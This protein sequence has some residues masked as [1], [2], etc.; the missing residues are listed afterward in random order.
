MWF[1]SLSL[2]VSI[3]ICT[4]AHFIE[5]VWLHLVTWQPYPRVFWD[6]AI[7]KYPLVNKQF[8]VEKMA[9]YCIES[10]PI[11]NGDVP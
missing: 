7:V 11:K 9:I 5:F 4:Y 6:P 10:F 1:V 2:F 3:R 8:A